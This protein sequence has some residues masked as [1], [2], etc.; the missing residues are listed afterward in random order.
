MCRRFTVVEAAMADVAAAA[1]ALVVKVGSVAAVAV[2]RVDAV[3]MAATGVL[4]L[5]VWTYRTRLVLLRMMNGIG[6]RIMVD[7]SM[8]I[9]LVTEW[10]VGD[11][12]VVVIVMEE[13]VIVTVVVVAA[14][15]QLVRLVTRL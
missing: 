6:F 11:V 4:W 3:D 14:S 5:T 9:R 2:A 1:D 12:V 7:S 15:A 10:P 13:V 8:Y